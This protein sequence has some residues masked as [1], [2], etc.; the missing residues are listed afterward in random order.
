MFKILHYTLAR[1]SNQLQVF[2]LKG[3]NCNSIL[4]P[5]RFEAILCH[6]LNVGDL[7]QQISSCSDTSIPVLILQLIYTKNT[8]SFDYMFLLQIPSCRN[9]KTHCTESGLCYFHCDLAATELFV[10]PS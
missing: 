9:V 1:E 6:S 10:P 8:V 7:L 4:Q 2:S 3:L 5:E